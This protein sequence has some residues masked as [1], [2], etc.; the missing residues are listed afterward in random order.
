MTD[1]LIAKMEPISV[2]KKHFLKLSIFCFII[3]IGV[4]LRDVYGFPINKFIFLAIVIFAFFALNESNL[5]AFISFLI[6]FLPGLPANFIIAFA[7]PFII[8]KQKNITVNMYVFSIYAYL[9]LELVHQLFSLSSLGEYSKFS[10]YIILLT[11]ILYRKDSNYDYPV[12]LLSYGIGVIA[13]FTAIIVHSLK[14]VSINSVFEQGIRIGNIA[15]VNDQFRATTITLTM[16][17]NTLGYFCSIAIA[18][19]LALLYAK[20]LHPIIAI[21]LIIVTFIYGSLTL[22]RTF[23]LISIGIFLYYF[24]VNLRLNKNSIKVCFSLFVMIVIILFTIIVYF[25]HTI[26]MLI[27][28]F[29]ESDITNGRG[30]IF[31]KYNQFM[32]SNLDNFLFGIGLQNMHIK[33][34]FFFVPHNGL[35]QIFVSGGVIGFL[36]IVFW[37]IGMYVNNRSK[38]KRNRF[39]YLLPLVTLFTY[40]QALQFLSPYFIMLPL[41]V[42]FLTLRLPD[43]IT[44]QKEKEN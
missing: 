2:S 13:S 34:N 28:R 6:P 30:M 17:Q 26:E 37:L 9:L 21:F 22:S 25:P 8:H 10:V 44:R 27:D 12:I 41:L 39:V 5:V 35:Q 20:K 16:D 14:Y 31:Q 3:F 15:Y 11:L 19:F 38:D 42:V 33:T 23:F 1:Y 32:F 4:F 24:I 43:S 7:I 36:L 40:I 29:Q 18:I